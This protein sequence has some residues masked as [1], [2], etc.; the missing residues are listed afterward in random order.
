MPIRIAIHGTAGRMGQRLVA[1]AS[2]DRE[3]CVAAALEHA[4]HP[5]LGSDAGTL[6]GVGTL[7]APL[8]A[9][10]AA[11]V[12]VVIDFSVP[13]ATQGILDLCLAN[14]LRLVVATTGLEPELQASIRQAS[15]QIPILWSP[16]MS[17]A[18]NL[19]M[20]L[21]E[22]AGCAEGSFLR[23]RRGDYRAPSSLQ[24]GRPQRHGLEVWRNHRRCHGANPTRAWPLGPARAAAAR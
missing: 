15:R 3:L 16:S 9:T 6:A 17:L 2:A 10:L 1:L 24:G 12:D 14:K 18:V 13:E 19:A 5:Q 22:M 4:A 7:D 21:A 20:K 8:A 23:R 11:P